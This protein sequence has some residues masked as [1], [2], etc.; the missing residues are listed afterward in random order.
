MAIRL[1]QRRQLKLFIM[2]DVLRA[3]REREREQS[4]VN[5]KNLWANESTGFQSQTSGGVFS[6]T[7]DTQFK[8]WRRKCLLATGSFSGK[9]MFNK[10]KWLPVARELPAPI[11]HYCCQV[12]KKFPLKIYERANKSNPILGTMAD[13]SRFR[14]QAW[15]R[16][17]CN[18]FDSKH[19]TSQPMSFW[20]EEDVLEYLRMTG[21]PYASVYG[22]L[23]D[24][25][26][27]HCTGVQRSGC[28]Y[29]GFGAHQERRED[30]RFLKLAVSHPRLYEY[31]I[32]GGQWV[33]NP[34]YDATASMKPDA[35]GWINWNPKKIWVPSKKGLGMGKVFDMMNEMYGKEMYKYK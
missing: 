16:H 8:N 25:P 23:E 9:S 27:L 24:N 5:E 18:A 30:S 35:M 4:T 6:E 13:E 3:Q 34:A 17:G 14:K 20:K 2:R 21:I 12:M 29:C 33:D 31:S 15:I 10:S 32:D 28:V 26:C 11:S 22:E 1:S 19:P 7:G